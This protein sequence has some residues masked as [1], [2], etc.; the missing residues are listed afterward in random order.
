VLGGVVYLALFFAVAIGK[1][2][3]AYYLA[4]ATRVTRRRRLQPAE[5]V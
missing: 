2:D 1:G 5:G 4:K 3:R